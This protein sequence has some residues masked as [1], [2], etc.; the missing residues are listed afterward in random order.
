MYQIG[1][2][3]TRRQCHQIIEIFMG[4]HKLCVF[5][6]KFSDSQKDINCKYTIDIRESIDAQRENYPKK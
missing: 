1:K 3:S 2:H 4:G 5:L 6:L